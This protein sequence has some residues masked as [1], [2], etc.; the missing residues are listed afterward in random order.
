ML[1]HQD[2]GNPR[3]KAFVEFATAEKAAETHDAMSGQSIDGRKVKV[4]FAADRGSSG[5]GGFGG[6]GRGGGSNGR[7]RGGGRGSFAG[8]RG[9]FNKEKGGILKSEGKKKTFDDSD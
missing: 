8:G 2:T 4:D 3:G 7:G 6:S 9:G 1:V 5:G